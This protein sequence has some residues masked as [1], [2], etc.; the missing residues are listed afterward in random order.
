MLNSL[1][2]I[3]LKNM[4][5]ASKNSYHVSEDDLRRLKEIAFHVDVIADSVIRTN[6]E[7]KADQE[8]V[9]TKAME[10]IADYPLYAS[11][12]GITYKDAI[13]VARALNPHWQDE[14]VEMERFNKLSSEE[15]AKELKAEMKERGL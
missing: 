10:Y 14:M 9:G 1:D 11:T 6:E 7:L 2:Y 3:H 15:Q 12:C 13:K 4:E 5:K 8:Q